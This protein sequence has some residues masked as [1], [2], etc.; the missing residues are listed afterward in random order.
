MY[1]FRSLADGNCLHSAMSV[2]LIRNKSLIHLLRILTLLKSFLNQDPVLTDVYI[3]MTA[4][5][6]GIFFLYPV[7]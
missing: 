3:N 6:E 5:Y 4:Q 7:N 2:R 1:L